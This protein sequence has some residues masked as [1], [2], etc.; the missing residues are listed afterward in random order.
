M[1][2]LRRAGLDL[3]AVQTAD[4]TNIA[5]SL[6]WGGD[7][8]IISYTHPLSDPTRRIHELLKNPVDLA[9]LSARHPWARSI[10]AECFDQHVPLALSLS[11]HPEFLMSS[12]L[13]QLFPYAQYLF[14]NVPEAL[15]VTG[16]S[17]FLK[18]LG[19]LAQALP[20]VIVTR[21][22]QGVV[23]MIEG[24][25]FDVPA[26]PSIMVDATGAGDVFA[27]TYLAATLKG[28]RP[29]GRLTA[30]NWAAA[31]AIQTVGSTPHLLRWE[32]I[33]VQ[34]LAEDNV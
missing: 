29:R 21:G 22:G 26:H 30:A 11:W 5:V 28:I 23:A 12:A 31:H 25:F 4:R 15:L 19:S 34:V 20:E 17:H 7:R 13:Q 24:E 14:S 32:D 3:S 16:E 6:N 33:A 2:R 1:S 9:L 8:S 10:A 18:A 27:A